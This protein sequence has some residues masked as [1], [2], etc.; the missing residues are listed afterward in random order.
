[1]EK[2][3]PRLFEPADFEG[4]V[5]EVN[6]PY[7][8]IDDLIFADCEF[9][10]AGYADKIILNFDETEAHVADYK[11]GLW[12]VTHAKENLQGLAYALGA[13]KKWK[14]LKKVVIH[15]LQPLLDARTT[16]TIYREDIPE[17]YFRIC[18]VVARARAAREAHAAEIAAGLIPSF[19]AAT[20]YAPTC[21]FCGHLGTCTKALGI[22][23]QVAHKFSPID[24]PADITPSMIHSDKDTSTSMRLA[25]V[26]STWAKA[27]KTC[28]TNRVINGDA[29]IPE[30]FQLVS[31]S[32]RE[33]V[34]LAAYRKQAVKII[35][36]KAFEETLQTT[37]GAV[38]ELIGEKAPRGLKKKIVLQF[39]KETEESGCV[40][41][42]LPITFLKAVP[43]KEA[44]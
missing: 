20:P 40:I 22:A 7:L 13:F 4:R 10:T 24:I 28:I 31:Q 11:F 8:P 34:D 29:E 44:E 2:Q 23:I 38:E 41:R 27:F 32:K 42:Q 3:V 37:F 18:A 19:S 5:K 43:K 21:S 35:G 14:T 6:E 12:P 1:M 15:F 26:V 39:Q 9:T 16:A 33:L 25:M 17:H 36:A 30:G